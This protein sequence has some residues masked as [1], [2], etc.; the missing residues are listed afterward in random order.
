LHNIIL[1]QMDKFLT[2]K[3]LNNFLAFC[4][5]YKIKQKDIAEICKEHRTNI[6]RSIKKKIFKRAN[7]KLVIMT[8]REETLKD[9]DLDF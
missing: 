9:F 4:K 1:L 2:D 7:A 3:E 6:S 5:K 8:Q